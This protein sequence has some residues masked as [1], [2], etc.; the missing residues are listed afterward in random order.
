MRTFI[1]LSLLIVLVAAR[2][3]PGGGQNGG[4]ASSTAAPTAAPTTTA[5]PV[6]TAEP[7]YGSVISETNPGDAVASNSNCGD[8]AEGYYE[9]YTADDTRYIVVSGAPSHPAEYDQDHAN[10]N[11]RCERW[12]YVAV[13]LE[14]S[15]SGSD[16]QALGVIGYVMSG[17]TVYDHRSSPQGDL[18]SYY[19]WDSLD[20]SFGH[21]DN[22]NQ[23]HYHAVPTEW[24]NSADS[25]A[26]EHIGYMIDGAKL[27]GYCE[28]NGSQVESC[29]VQVSDDTPTNESDYEYTASSTC[30]L[31]E[32]N[33][34]EING[35]MAYVMTPNYPY[36]P[37]CLK[38]SA[39][40]INGF[41][42]EDLL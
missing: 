20:P 5:V 8:N 13:P 16:Y 41:T 9:E 23:Y 17:G 15:A 40:D 6:T 33:M 22:N 2:R 36:V 19:E 37:P 21:S 14:W 27:Y 10:P 7:T 32:C 4:S 42:P 29:Y 1:L 24:S 35:E 26:C 30:L 34:M 18:A 11:T 12:Q 28:A 3:K 31:D 25:S 39:A 38:G